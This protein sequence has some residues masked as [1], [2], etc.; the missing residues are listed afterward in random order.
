MHKEKKASI[1][2]SSEN[3]KTWNLSWNTGTL[4]HNSPTWIWKINKAITI[5]MKQLKAHIG[6][7]IGKQEVVSIKHRN[8]KWQEFRKEIG[9]KIISEIKIQLQEQKRK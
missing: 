3:K 1:S 9:G 6:A 4:Y 2:P 5:M 7:H 8:Y